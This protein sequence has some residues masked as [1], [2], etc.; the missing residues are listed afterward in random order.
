MTLPSDSGPILAISPHLDDAVMGVG[1]T[2]AALCETGR[3]VVVCTVFAGDPT[4]ELSPVAEAFHADCG[5]GSDAVRRRR[6]EDDEAVAVLGATAVHL[7]FLDAIYRRSGNRWLCETPRAM[8]DDDQPDESPLTL[9]ISSAVERLVRELE[10]SAVWTCAAIGGHVDHRRTRQ[11]VERSAQRHGWTAALWEG[12][13]YAFGLEPP[14][15][16]PL[17]AV[18]V[19]NAHLTLKLRAIERYRSQLRMLFDESDDWHSLFLD[20][21]H[22]RRPIGGPELLWPSL[23][24][25]S[26]HRRSA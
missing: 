4:G 9:A 21:A 19:T 7:P 17:R 2:I 18:T 12:V 26:R 24:D 16:E 20:H 15:V 1:A 8:F 23:C 22:A 13:P 14:N 25:P 5:L 3:D 6:A 11:A 10:P